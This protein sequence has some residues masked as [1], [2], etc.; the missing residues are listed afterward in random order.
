[1]KF[2]KYGQILLALV[3]SLGL[4][5]GLTSCATDYTVAYLYITSGQYSQ[6]GAFKI[7][8]NTGALS[9][10]PGAPFG[11]GGKNPVRAVVSSTGRYLYVL[12][13]GDATVDSTGNISY[14]GANI[15]VYSIGGN[16]TLAFQ[17]SYT[18]QG[19]GSLRL[20]ISQTGGFMYVL[21]E[22]APS[23]K[24]GSTY[25]LGS[26]TMQTGLDCQDTS[27]VYHPTGDIT[28]FSVDSNTGRLSL[29]TNNQVQNPDG[30]S[31]SYF[32]V[33][34]GP[35]DFKI[36]G[37]Y[38]LTADTKDPI[39]GNSLTIFPYA[40]NSSS[41]QLTVTQ[42][43]EFVTGAASISNIGSNQGISYIYVLDPLNNNILY[44]TIGSN[45][46]LQAVN[47]SPTSNSASNAGNP[48]QVI[49]D[50]KNRFLYVANAG[51]STNL[52]NS[53]SDITGYTIATNGQLASTSPGRFTTG[54]GPQCILEDPSNQYIYTAD[55]N[56]STVTGHVLDPGSGVLTPT[57]NQSSYPTVGNPTWC[58][59][60]GHTD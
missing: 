19:F 43:T 26:K 60:S 2:K 10:I 24:N 49:S 15:S 29:I 52:G 48:I 16:G 20:G 41:G 42:N 51:P 21:D 57:R 3:V 17:Q 18:S 12:N 30:T 45:G 47:G 39:T 53:A 28:V 14:T 33:G 55:Y 13:E 38:I 4:G 27:G 9:G 54:S 36:T 40:L 37:G 1:M 6:I 5:F 34:C 44:F 23:V 7:G 31:L 8:N 56:T 11:S 58:V 35:I 22:Y 50:S 25:I 59:A 32:P 46:L